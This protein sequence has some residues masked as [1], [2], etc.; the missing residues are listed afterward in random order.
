[1]AIEPLCFLRKRS[2]VASQLLIRNLEEGVYC[3]HRKRS[4]AIC[5]AAITIR[6][7][8]SPTSVRAVCSFVRALPVSLFFEEGQL[9][10][11]SHQR[12]SLT[13]GRNSVLRA[14]KE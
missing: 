8:A 13:A 3:L 6:S 9:E 7:H 5:F 14:F 2:P 11:P 10:I 1:M 4:R 12:R